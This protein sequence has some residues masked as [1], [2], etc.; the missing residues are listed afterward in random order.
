M[1]LD[2]PPASARPEALLP[3]IDVVF[4]L[5]VFFMMV[6]QFAT[7]EPFKVT[8]PAAQAGDAVE[9]DYALYL[10]AAGEVG[11]AGDGVVTTGDGAIEALIAARDEGCAR[12]EC[13]TNAPAL[14]LHADLGAPAVVL[15]GLLP[16]LAAAGFA[17]VRLI[18][19]TP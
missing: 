15:A 13:S 6:S 17:D 5:I 3:M 2:P 18:T 14:V 16:K 12:R 19:V 11:F 4:F 10:S 9:G 8:N 1:R 7:P